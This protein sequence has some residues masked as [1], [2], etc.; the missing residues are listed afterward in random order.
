[1]LNHKILKNNLRS[2]FN[3]Q[4]GNF[5]LMSELDIQVKLQILN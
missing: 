4:T 3:F 2:K 1:M 5:V